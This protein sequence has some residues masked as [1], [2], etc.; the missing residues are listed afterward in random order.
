M[1]NSHNIQ[2]EKGHS[3]SAWDAVTKDY[4]L[5]KHLGSGSYGEVKKAIHRQSKYRVAIKRI[6]LPA[7]ADTRIYHSIIREIKIL[8]QLSKHASNSH[9][10]RLIDVIVAEDEIKANKIKNIFLVMDYWKYT[11]RTVLDASIN[12]YT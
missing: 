4:E 1:Q 3:K 5:Q 9:S 12:N 7:D 10:V 8:R 6:E 11:L 2:T